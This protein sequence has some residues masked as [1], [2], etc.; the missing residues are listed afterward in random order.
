MTSRDKER[1]HRKTLHLPNVATTSNVPQRAFQ[2]FTEGSCANTVYSKVVAPFV[3]E[4]RRP[5]EL[6]LETGDDN[7]DAYERHPKV[8]K[9]TIPFVPGTNKLASIVCDPKDFLLNLKEEVVGSNLTYEGPRP[10]HRFYPNSLERMKT[11]VRVLRSTFRE[12]GMDV[13]FRHAYDL[14]A[15][16]LGFAGWQQCTA[17]WDLFPAT[18]YDEQANDEVV[19]ARKEH[20]I[21]MLLDSGLPDDVASAIYSVLRPTGIRFK[22]R[23]GDE[24]IWDGFED[25]DL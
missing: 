14:L 16:M 21:R 9:A 8:G 11:K 15:R 13:K 1:L 6:S 10:S 2:R 23:P 19:L 24:D 5:H 17:N 7:A 4:R 18:P 12:Q 25:I 3:D 20:Q 22:Y